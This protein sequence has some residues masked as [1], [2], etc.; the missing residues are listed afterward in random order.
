MSFNLLDVVKSHLTPDL[1][2]KLS[3]SLG[4]NNNG[5]SK[6]ISAILPLILGGLTT[7]AAANEQSANDVFN[8]ASEA[9][10]TGA[11][12]NI[13][14]LL[15]NSGDLLTKATGWLQ[16]IFGDKANSIIETVAAFAGIKSSSASSILNVA[17]PVTLGALG[18]HIQSNGLNSSDFAN[19]LQSQKSNILSAL[20]GNISS[21]LGF[22]GITTPGV[23]ATATAPKT[24]HAAATHD[25][26]HES[27][28]GSLKWLLPL[29]ILVGLGLLAWYFA[30]GGCGKKATDTHDD[31]LNHKTTIVE[32]KPVTV[33]KGQ[34]DTLGNY[35][36][37]L[38]ADKT[39]TLSDG[40]VLHV[41]E[42]STEA[43]LFEFLNNNGKSVDTVDKAKEWYTLDRVYFET[44][45]SV[46]TAASQQQI[47]NIAAILKMFPNAQ[48]KFGGYTDNTGAADVNTR[49]SGERAKVALNETVKAGITA[50]RLASEGYGPLHPVC[51]PNDTPECKAQNRRVDI[52]VTKK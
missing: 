36:Y 31:T 37:D 28:T 48:V 15:G 4:E 11:L 6:A 21:L 39:I 33:I 32:D 27:K 46:L 5:I 35:I 18:N 20:P 34:L 44:G 13:S 8:L 2:S 26:H 1:I 24:H 22:A 30:G 7:K 42:H 9:N 19:L 14:G 43:R 16:S 23:T 12:S 47:K 49:I 45:K 41:G 17:T 50:D 3:N 40:T 29:L 51:A 38:G 25:V 10:N 52:R